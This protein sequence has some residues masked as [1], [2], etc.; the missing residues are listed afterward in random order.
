MQSSHLVSAL[1][2]IEIF[3]FQSPVGWLGWSSCPLPLQNVSVP[4]CHRAA[5]LTTPP[6]P[7]VAHN[8]LFHPCT[9]GSNI[10]IRQ[11]LNIH[12]R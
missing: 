7:L 8:I 4:W 10:D 9:F 2:R 1:T 3:R 6:A 12:R 5:H 11:T